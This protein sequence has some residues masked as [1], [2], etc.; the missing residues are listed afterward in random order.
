[1]HLNNIKAKAV[2]EDIAEEKETGIYEENKD[3]IKKGLKIILIVT[4]IYALISLL[5]MNITYPNAQINNHNLGMMPISKISTAFDD[6]TIKIVGRDNKSI[7]L[8]AKEA[9][10]YTNFE[11]DAVYTQKA[12]KWPVEIAQGIN[13]QY[14][15]N[16]SVDVEKLKKTLQESELFTNITEPQ[17]AKL[18]FGEKEVTI[19]PET[20]GNKLD[21]DKTAE[22]VVAGFKNDEELVNLDS[23]YINP[24]IVAADLESQRDKLNNILRT[25]VKINMPD[26]SEYTVDNSSLINENY[27]F[28]PKRVRMLVDDIK[29]KYEVIGNDYDFTTT[30]GSNINVTAEVFGNEINKE[31][32]VEN[33]QKALESGKS[34]TIDL[35]Y[36]RKSSNIDKIGNTYIEVDVDNQVMYYYINGELA[37][38]TPVVTGDPTT[39]ADT[40]RGLFEIWVKETDRFLSGTDMSGKPYKVPVAYWMQIDYTGVGLHDTP[41]RSAF[42]GNIYMGNGSLGCI[43]TPTNAV[44]Y[45]YENAAYG[46]PV[47]IY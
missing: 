31:K 21:L 2:E 11:D 29:A 6:D 16:K 3:L 42:G 45:I 15:V 13:H 35:A 26:G 44:A 30:S 36:D 39:G 19:E 18:A 24:K 28:E 34:S 14:K 33:I 8:N 10:L 41:T 9:G 37:L 5:F 32:T 22:A 12:Y 25:E 43:N 4:G 47:I 23:E 46:T 1:M 7:E 20:P 27:E 17:N 40:P 38:S